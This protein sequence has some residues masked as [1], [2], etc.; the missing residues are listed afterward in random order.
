[1]SSAYKIESEISRAT[2][3][4]VPLPPFRFNYEDVAYVAS[5][6]WKAPPFDDMKQFGREFIEPSIHDPRDIVKD[7]VKFPPAMMHSPSDAPGVLGG[8]L[9]E[10][11]GEDEHGNSLNKADYVSAEDRAADIA[12]RYAHLGV[13]VCAGPIPTSEECAA[14]LK[15]LE[16]TYKSRIA[17]S[18]EEWRKSKSVKNTVSNAPIA[19]RYFGLERDWAD[20]VGDQDVC[21]YCN[22]AVRSKSVKCANQGCGAILDWKRAR[23]AGIVSKAEYDEHLA[24][25]AADAEP[26][27]RGPGRPPK[28]K[29]EVEL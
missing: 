12:R 1:M 29:D 22:R 11:H 3:N 10:T 28:P 5:L 18:D 16:R 17:M 15:M 19:L 27:K 13:F 25:E 23:Q 14:A 4:K 7:P 2:R 8:F 24:E 6:Y 20:R 9:P 26:A 21:P